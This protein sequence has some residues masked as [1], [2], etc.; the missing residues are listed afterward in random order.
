MGE[1]KYDNSAF[2]EQYSKMARSVK[3][4]AGAGEWHAFQKLMPDF[5]GKRVL[6]LGCGFGWHCI[7]AE[8]HGAQSV[9][10]IDLSEKMIAEAKKKTTSDKIEYRQQGIEEF[11]YQPNQFDVVLSSLAFHYL[12]S[13]E[14]ICQKVNKCLVSGGEFVFSVEHPI[15]TAEGRQD[16]TYDAE[17][18]IVN[19]P[20]DSYFNESKRK[21]IFL[22][23]EV[24]KYHKTMTTYLNTLLNNGFE[25]TQIVEPLPDAEMLDTVPGMRDELRRP[26]MLLIAARKK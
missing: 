7:Y 17:G 14:S 13:F 16:W 24:V 10:G 25:I 26:M 9:I 12:E 18:N 21:S 1:N 5:T 2:F 15:F 6:D 3:G 19:W 22:G 23:E 20:V 4:L 11:D 8:E